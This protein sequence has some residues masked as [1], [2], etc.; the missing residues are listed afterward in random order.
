MRSQSGGGSL[1]ILS[2]LLSGVPIGADDVMRQQKAKVRSY[3]SD[4][5]LCSIMGMNRK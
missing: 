5:Y 3:M 1:A 2:Q 4:F